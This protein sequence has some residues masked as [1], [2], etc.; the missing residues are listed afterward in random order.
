[1]GFEPSQPGHPHSGSPQRALGRWSLRCAYLFLFTDIRCNLGERSMAG[2]N[3]QT[4]DQ[5]IHEASGGLLHAETQRTVQASEK[6]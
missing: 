2:A 1:M 4:K 5:S 6:K 3:H